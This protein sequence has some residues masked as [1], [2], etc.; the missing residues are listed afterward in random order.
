M[1]SYE[2]PWTFDGKEFDSED[3]GNSYGFVYLIST[4]TGQKYI[5]RKY[6]WSIRKAKGKSRRQR[7][8]SDWKSY[9]GSSEV[10]KEQIKQSDKSLFK[11]EIISLHS[12]KGRVNYEEVREQFANEVLENDEFINDNINGKWHRSPEHIRSK[13]RFSAIASRRTHGSNPQ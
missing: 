8:E 10:L 6:F 3:I 1:A 12:T 13:S 9:Y 7:S 4:P 11:R 5:G 2:N